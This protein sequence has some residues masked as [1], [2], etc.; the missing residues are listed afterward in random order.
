[1]LNEQVII[2]NVEI[3]KCPYLQKREDEYKCELF[4]NE[5]CLCEIRDNCY[6]KQFKIKEWE[7]EEL[8]IY[9]ESNEQ[10]VKEVEKLVMDNDRLIN[11][12][13]Q[14]KAENETYK[15]MLE[16]EEVILALN[17]VRT[18]ER[19]L[20]FNKSIKRKQTLAEIKEIAENCNYKNILD[21][22]ERTTNE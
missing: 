16:D 12:L 20:W 3:S 10:Q 8:K 5:N 18:G 4:Y 15:K 11:E 7:V 21:V 1:M 17:E 2:N 22:I 13:N 19:H 14:L 9:I 6:Y